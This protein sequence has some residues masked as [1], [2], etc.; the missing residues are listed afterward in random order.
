MLSAALEFKDVFPRYQQRDPTY[1]YLP[2]VEDWKKVAEVCSFLEEFNQA[3]QII[4]GSEYPTSNLFL[5][6]LYVI[7][8]LLNEKMMGEEYFMKSMVKKMK[9]KFDKYWG[10]CNLLI[11]MAAVLDPRY[12]MLFI[13]WCFPLVY[14][15]ADSIEH[16]SSVREA[17]HMLYNEYLEAHRANNVEAHGENIKESSSSTSSTGIEKSRG[18]DEVRNYIR[19]IEM[20][21][22]Q[23]KSELDVYLEG[24]MS[25]EDD[26]VF[27]VLEWWKMNTLKFRI[28]SKMACDIL[29]IPITTVAS[30]YAFSAE[31]RVIDQYRASLGADTTQ[32]LLCGED[33]FRAFYGIKRK[34][35]DKEDI[36]EFIIP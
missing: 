20:V 18:K 36:K 8:R 7:K 4:S 13:E 15:R 6:E 21:F 1:I 32:V 27:N 12:K 3:T 34:R 23:V 11:S 25:C 9:D 10:N 16:I 2:S 5:S 17:L 14:S 33:W 28:L 24:V 19:N 22:E 26:S 29:S 35:K 30:E 31:S